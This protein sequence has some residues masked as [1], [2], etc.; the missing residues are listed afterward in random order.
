[1]SKILELALLGMLIAGAGIL[2]WWLFIATEGVYLGRRVV[3][4]LY[5]LYANRYDGIKNYQREYEHIF[6]AQPIMEAIAPNRAPLVLDVATG[7]GRL[8]LALV[9][10][11]GF[12]GRIVG[13]DLSRRMLHHATKNIYPYD[14]LVDFIWCPAE[15]LPF[16]DN[17]FDVVTCLEALE[18]MSNPKVSAGGNCP[19]PASRWNS[20]DHTASKHQTDARE[21]MDSK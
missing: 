13:T 12:K 18:F 16:A 2:V 3:I 14:E 10:H 5:D 17:T 6:L 20:V 8:P 7:T 11:G 4:W 1:M 9:R 21:N 15:K 19:C